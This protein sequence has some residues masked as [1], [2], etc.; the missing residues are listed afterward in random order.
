MLS[1][2]QRRAVVKI[3]SSRDQVPGIQG[4]AGSGK[5]TSLAA[6]REAAERHGYAVEGLALTL[7]AAEELAT[8]GIQARTLQYHLSHGETAA[9]ARATSSS[10]STNRAWRAP[11]RSTTS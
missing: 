11:G 3:L 8:V 2:S 9:D 10:L 1:E 7:R 6:I 5:T 4:T